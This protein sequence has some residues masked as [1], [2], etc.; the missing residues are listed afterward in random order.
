MALRRAALSLDTACEKE[1][2]TFA[3]L[4][5]ETLGTRE[6]RATHR[7][8]P[9]SALQLQAAFLLE[10]FP[11]SQLVPVRRLFAAHLQVVDGLQRPHP[12][13]LRQLTLR[14]ELTQR[15]RTMLSP[16]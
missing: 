7:R 1:S 12:R 16:N 15:G 5:R 9:P 3:G 14:V 2:V 6:R 10:G 11:G 4:P 13:L 8:L